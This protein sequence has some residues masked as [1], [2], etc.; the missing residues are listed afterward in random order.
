M[1]GPTTVHLNSATQRA[2]KGLGS[3]ETSPGGG[4][5][6]LIVADDED[7][8]VPAT[9]GAIVVLFPGSLSESRTVTIPSASEAPMSL[10]VIATQSISDDVNVNIVPVDK[11][12]NS[13]ALY[14]QFLSGGLFVTLV[15][16]GGA[17]GEALWW[18]LDMVQAVAPILNSLNDVL[19]SMAGIDAPDGGDVIDV[20]A[21]AFIAALLTALS[22]FN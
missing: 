10:T 9:P 2:L 11:P 5:Q 17:P 20:E 16:D 21:R 13:Y 8:T 7:V 22:P 18:S 14:H 12:D 6:T 3:G 19:D 15:N 4:S 1:S